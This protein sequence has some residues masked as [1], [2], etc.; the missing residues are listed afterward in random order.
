MYVGANVRARVRAF[1][2]ACV[3]NLKLDEKV[4]LQASSQAVVSRMRF[5]IFYDYIY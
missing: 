4:C 2:R 5:L 3:C 1:V